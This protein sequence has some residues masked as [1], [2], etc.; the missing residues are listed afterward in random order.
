MLQ[1]CIEA[2]RR[3]G[4]ECEEHGKHMEHCRICAE[5]CRACEQ[6]CREALESLSSGQ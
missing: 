5:S 2:S 6:A 4:D 1:A 3:C